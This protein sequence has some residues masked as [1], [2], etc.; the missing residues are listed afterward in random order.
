MDDEQLGAGFLILTWSEQAI[1]KDL[2]KAGQFHAFLE[3]D[4]SIII[5]LPLLP[6]FPRLFPVWIALCWEVIVSFERF[7]LMEEAS[8]MRRSLKIGRHVW[9]LE[10]K[11]ESEL[12]GKREG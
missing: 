5:F 7:C 2:F 1:Y 9:V 12:V 10:F 6:N 8:K 3:K 11:L 4:A